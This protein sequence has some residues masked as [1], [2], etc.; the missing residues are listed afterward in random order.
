MTNIAYVVINNVSTA[1]NPGVYVYAAWA[2]ETPEGA[3]VSGED[4]TSVPVAYGDTREQI[5]AAL[6][7]A[8]RAASDDTAL[9]VRFIN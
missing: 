2:S 6:V 7:V 1:S 8:I 3:S 4:A 5:R 9:E